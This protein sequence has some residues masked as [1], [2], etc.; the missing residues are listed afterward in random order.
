MKG[1]FQGVCIPLVM[2]VQACVC[3]RPGGPR[4]FVVDVPMCIDDYSLA[5]AE[6]RE[7]LDPRVFGIPGEDPGQGLLHLEFTAEGRRYRAVYAYAHLLRE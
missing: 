7:L 3:E 6:G 2:L 4:R 1:V 5:R